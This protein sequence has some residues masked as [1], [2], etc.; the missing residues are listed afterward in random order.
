PRDRS[1]L[2]MQEEDADRCLEGEEPLRLSLD[3]QDRVLEARVVELHHVRAGGSLALEAARQVDVHD[4]ESTRA[5]REVAS[6]DVHHDLVPFARTPYERDIGDRGSPLAVYLDLHPLNRCGGI[7]GF[8]DDP[9]A[10][11]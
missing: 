11:L 6:L 1:E 10:Q 2:R 5:E 7:T 8:D 3:G 9:A 4:V